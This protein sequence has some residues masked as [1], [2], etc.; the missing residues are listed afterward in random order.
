VVIGS[1]PS[2]H[3]LLNNEDLFPWIQASRKA[4]HPRANDFNQSS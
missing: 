4:S 2:H 1:L 3:D